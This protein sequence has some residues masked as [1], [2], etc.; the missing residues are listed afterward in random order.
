MKEIYF[1]KKSNQHNI[2]SIK[3]SSRNKYAGKLIL[4]PQLIT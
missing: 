3:H 2:A 1:L 4:I